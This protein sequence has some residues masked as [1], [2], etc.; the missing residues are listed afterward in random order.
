MN[1]EVE[2]ISKVIIQPS[3]PTPERL[4]RYQLSFLDQITPPV[5][6]PLVLFYPEKCDTQESKIEISNQLKQ[7]ISNAL[8]YFNPLAGRIRDNLFVDCNDEGIPFVE[9]RVKCQLSEVIKDPVPLELNKLFPF[10][11]YDAGE[12]PLGIQFNIFDCRGIG[13]GVCISHKL[14]DAL[15]FF[16]FV[17]MWAAIARGEKKL[18]TPEFVSASLF[19]PRSITGYNPNIRQTKEKII[20]K[21]FVFTASKIEEIRGKYADKTSSENPKRP[22]RIEALSAF[23]WSR[24]VVATKVISRPDTFCAVFHLVNLRTRMD[25]PLAD[26]SFGNLYS[27]ATTVPSMDSRENCHNLVSQIRDSIRKINVEYVKKVQDGQDHLDYIKEIAERPIRGETSFFSCTSLCRFP[28]YEADFG[29]G[30]PIWVGSAA[31]ASTNGVIFLDSASG[32]GIEAW[33]N[34]K[35]EDM[36]KFDCDEE[37]LAYIA[38]KNN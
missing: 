17:N 12:L 1:L 9:A 24:F 5:Y 37:L 29:W 21:R 8:T 22:T 26:Y 2:V 15:S 6:N 36:A 35:E 25:P 31:R 10:D 28:L 11:L 23:I 3:S 13:V 16:T 27:F 33:V 32:D 30:K 20:T 38:P 14:G 19:P 34:L 7:S 18:V 4:R